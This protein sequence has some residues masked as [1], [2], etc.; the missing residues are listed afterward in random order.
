MQNAPDLFIN[1]PT[2]LNLWC[3]TLQACVIS[4]WQ[5][6]AHWPWHCIQT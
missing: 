6:F 3:N 2:P 1:A 5:T 4:T